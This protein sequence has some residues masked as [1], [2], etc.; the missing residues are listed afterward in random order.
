MRLS[1]AELRALTWAVKEAETWR[2]GLT[3]NPDPEPLKRFD[4]SIA[5]AK[6]ALKKLRREASDLIKLRRQQ[7]L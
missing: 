6:A 4:E 3:G 7:R 2:G 5:M 1:P